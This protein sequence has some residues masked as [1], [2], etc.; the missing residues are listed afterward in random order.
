M[1]TRK[2]AVVTG[3]SRGL[4]L[5]WVK[6]LLADG[7]E[8]FAVTRGKG[9]TSDALYG[10]SPS[11]SLKIVEA[12]LSTAEGLVTYVRALPQYLNLLINN[13]GVYLD[14]DSTFEELDFNDVVR[15]FEINVVL[16]M[17]VTR[18][19]LPALQKSKHPIVVQTTSLMGSIGDNSSGGSYA[20]RMSKAALNMFHKSFSIDHPN[21]LSLT[22]HPGWVR[23]EMGGPQAPVLPAKS[24][25]GMLSVVKRSKLN[26]DTGKFFDFEGD[27][28]PW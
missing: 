6:Q 19:S 24:V 25:S 1:S 3:A 4:G 26:S 13:A 5:E 28:L 22:F 23:T 8:V 27:E 16:P 9:S 14:G 11:S 10:L 15:T 12:D 21:I 20:Y 17:R 18:A 7:Y 2:T